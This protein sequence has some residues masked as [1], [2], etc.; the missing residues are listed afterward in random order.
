MPRATLAAVTL[1]LSFVVLPRAGRAADVVEFVPR[2]AFGF[3]VVRN[4]AEVDAKIQRLASLLQLPEVRPLAL[5]QQTTGVGAGIDTRGDVLVALLPSRGD[6]FQFEYSVW[7]PVSDYDGLLRSLGGTPSPGIAEVRVAGEDLLIARQDNW[8][9]VMDPD[10]RE[11]MEQQLIRPGRPGPPWET[12][13]QWARQND[14]TVVALGRGVQLLASL[15]LRAYMR[16]QQAHR[17]AA[18]QA[19]DGLA[20]PDELAEAPDDLFGP[21]DQDN[22]AAANGRDA[23]RGSSEQMADLLRGFG[24]MQRHS[25]SLRRLTVMARAVGVGLQFDNDANATVEV[26]VSAG[27][28][29]MWGEA[30]NNGVAGEP[31]PA[32]HGDGPFIV[33]GAGQ[34]PPALTA[35]A[36]NTYAQLLIDEMRTQ[37][38][39]Q[40]DERVVVRFARAVEQTAASVLSAGVLTL[41][42]DKQDGVYT[43]NFA[44]VRVAAAAN[45]VDAVGETLRLWNQMTR[46]AEGG[47]RLVFDVAETTIGTRTATRYTL[48]VAAADGA[49]ELP[50]IRQA[51]EKLFGPGGKLTLLVVKVDEQ[52]VLLA[53]ATP[54]QVA[55]LLQRLDQRLAADWNGPATAVANRLLPAEARWRA[56]FS[57]HDYTTWLARQMD[58]I[59]GVPVVGGPLVREFPAAPPIGAAGGWDGNDPWVRFSMPNETLRGAAAYLHGSK[60]LV[61]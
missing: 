13:P 26:R 15:S 31:L 14:V 52:T 6:P 38:G 24:R 9:L 7:L 50:E 25:N 45:F 22:A 48:D 3:A 43:N 21:A 55:T 28:G 60:D 41:P 36:V 61:P 42:G 12:W 33:Y 57:P 19:A 54:E 56:F 29:K 46:D 37:E 8:A 1:V 47:P 18:T 53:V 51:M 59:V 27:P 30:A 39:M 16:D 44:V 23:G 4:F 58:A 10:Q 20:P 17:A 34:W 5:L 40:L 49:P 11:L 2:N 35:A 32:L